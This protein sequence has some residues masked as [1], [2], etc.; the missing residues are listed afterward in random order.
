MKTIFDKIF[1]SQLE[2]ID[3]EH[4]FK[5]IMDQNTKKIQKAFTEQINE[6]IEEMQL[7]VNSVRNQLVNQK[8]KKRMD[9]SYMEE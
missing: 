5:S 9:E 3:I 7:Q 4:K 6:E 2:K 1:E 8:K